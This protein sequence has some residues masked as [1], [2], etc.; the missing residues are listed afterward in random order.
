MKMSEPIS[1][2]V[3]L[4]TEEIEM[5]V[6]AIQEARDFDPFSRKTVHDKL[7]AALKDA[8]AREDADLIPRNG[9]SKRRQVALR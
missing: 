9:S 7:W 5:L 8:A 6:A 1:T 2:N 4:T 3:L